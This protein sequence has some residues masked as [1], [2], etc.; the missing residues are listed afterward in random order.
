MDDRLAE[1]AAAVAYQDLRAYLDARGWHSFPSR[2][3]YAAI[4]RSPGAGDFEVQIPLDTDL[5][6]YADAIVFAA[7][8]IAA[9]EDRPVEQVLRDLLQPRCDTVRYA[10]TGP[11]TRTGT[12]SLVAGHALVAGA[13]KS[14]LASACSVQRPRRFHPRMTLSDAESYVRACRLGQTE[15]GSYVLTVETPLDIHAQLDATEIPFGRRAT[16]YLFESTAYLARAIRQGETARILEENPDAPLVSANLC[17]SLLEMMPPDES[18]DLRLTGS[19]S[20]LIPPPASV[21]SAVHFDRTMFEAVERLA[22]QLRPSRDS[23]PAQFVGKVLELS[24]A[25]NAA[26]QLEGDVVLQVQADDQLL[27]VRVPLGPEDY[28]DAGAAHL[29]QHYVSVRGQLH[30]GPRIHVLKNPTGFQVVK[31]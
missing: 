1:R 16:A 19:W 2:V 6:D 21:P 22:Q 5:A 24:G 7:R 15:I 4:Y 26:G 20:P 8:R 23:E 27:K 3:S 12:I 17:E 18:A 10:V 29:A 31:P 9:F 25:P 11:S 14:L 13:L 28:K 30:R